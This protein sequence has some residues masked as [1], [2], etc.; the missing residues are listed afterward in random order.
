MSDKNWGV[1]LIVTSAI[2]FAAISF[3]LYTIKTP[4]AS[5][6]MKILSRGVAIVACVLQLVVFIMFSRS[7]KKR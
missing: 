6:I 4:A 3:L 1:V 7:L 5:D 2:L